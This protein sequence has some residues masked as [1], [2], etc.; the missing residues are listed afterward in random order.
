MASV[1]TADLEAALLRKGFRKDNTHHK[2][3]WL[4]DGEKRTHVHTPISHGVREYGDPLLSRVRKQ[5]SLE[6]KTQLLNLVGCPLSQQEYL[7][8][9]VQKRIVIRS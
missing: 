7:N 3:Y 1:K 2:Y 8:I 5:L 6:T 9:L 4:Y